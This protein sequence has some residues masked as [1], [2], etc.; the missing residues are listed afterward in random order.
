MTMLEA[1]FYI[2]QAAPS[3][4]RNFENIVRTKITGVTIERLESNPTEILYK[5]ATIEPNDLL[6][7]GAAISIYNDELNHYQ[8]PALQKTPIVGGNHG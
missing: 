3:V 4:V 6:L 8:R 2:G 7:L 5:A 1:T